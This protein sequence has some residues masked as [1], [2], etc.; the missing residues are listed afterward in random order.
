MNQYCDVEKKT[1]WAS[2]CKK[3]VFVLMQQNV[4]GRFRFNF[5]YLVPSIFSISLLV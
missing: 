3:F 2:K 4:I 1:F 5:G